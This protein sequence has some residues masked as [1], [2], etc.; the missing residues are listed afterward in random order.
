VVARAAI[1]GIARCVD[2][3][4]SALRMT[5]A[6]LTGV[7]P[8]AGVRRSSIRATI[9]VRCCWS[10]IRGRIL[11]SQLVETEDGVAPESRKR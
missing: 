3:T 10:R 11:E 6:C 9:R 8:N 5:T 4:S 2:A 7:V 1:L